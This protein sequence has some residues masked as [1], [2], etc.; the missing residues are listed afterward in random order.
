MQTQGLQVEFTT[1]LSQD[2]LI[3]ALVLGE[4][5]VTGSIITSAQFEAIRQTPGFRLV[6]DKGY[7]APEGCGYSVWMARSELIE[8]GALEDLSNLRNMVI[9][10]NRSISLNLYSLDTLLEPTGMRH[11]DIEIAEVPDPNRL[12]AFS[13]GAIDIA[14]MT[15]PW[16]TRTLQAGVAQVWKTREEISP[17]AQ[18]ATLWYGP[19]LTQVNRQAGNRFMVAYLNAVRQYNEGKTERNVELMSEFTQLEPEEARAMCWQVFRPDGTMNLESILDF[20][21]WAVENGLMDSIVPI[22]EFWD[23]SFIEYASDVLGN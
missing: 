18:L 3:V 20:Q 22:D 17:G 16:V 6:A 7:L 8:S 23:D 14:A 2:D 1:F 13:N 12:E 21:N 5:D 10:T 4:I 9:A 11:A 15:E 19:S